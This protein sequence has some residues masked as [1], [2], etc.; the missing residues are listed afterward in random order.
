M[1]LYVD[2]TILVS[3]SQDELQCSLNA[4]YDYCGRSKLT[5]NISKTKVVIFSKGKLHNIPTFPFCNEIIDV[6]ENYTYLGTVFTNNGKFREAKAKQITQAKRAIYNLLGKYR[7]FSFPIDIL[8]NLF[9]TLI[10][11]ILLYGSEIWVV[12][13]IDNMESIQLCFFKYLLNLHKSTPNCM[14]RGEV[15]IQPLRNKINIK[16]LCYCA[17]LIMGKQS[18][19]A[20]NIYNILKQKYETGEYIYSHG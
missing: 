2:D 12:T 9:E 11:P 1:L 8:I 15:G 16:I 17:R 4:L 6:Q 3:S 14:L 18:K 10:E 20:Y 13:D 7:K 5:I 19:I